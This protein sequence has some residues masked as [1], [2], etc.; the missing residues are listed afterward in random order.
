MERKQ[1]KVS[2]LV[3]L[4]LSF[5]FFF[6]CWEWTQIFTSHLMWVLQIYASSS[7]MP[8]KGAKHPI[9]REICAYS[10]IIMFC[11][12]TEKGYK[13]TMKGRVKCSSCRLSI[14]TV[15]IWSAIN[16]QGQNKTHHLARLFGVQKIWTWP[17]SFDCW[18]QDV[19]GHILQQQLLRNSQRIVTKLPLELSW[20]VH[21]D[22]LYRVPVC[23]SQDLISTC[24][25]E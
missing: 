25:W 15:C 16:K 19:W 12:V 4:M 6:S 9:V 5:W 21:S 2:V 22:L 3:D 20:I 7:T 24:L 10:T 13:I 18:S 11:S 23:L 1:V 17:Y 14:G 8:G